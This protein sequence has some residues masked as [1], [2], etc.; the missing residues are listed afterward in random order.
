MGQLFVT[1]IKYELI[2]MT[3]YKEKKIIIITNYF[4]KKKKENRKKTLKQITKL[5]YKT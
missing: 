4:Q 1:T 3:K 5:S 2:L